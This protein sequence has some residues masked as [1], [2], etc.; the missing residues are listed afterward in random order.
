ME[1]PK[2]DGVQ[3]V[4]RALQ[5]LEILATSGERGVSELATEIGVHKSTTS[6]LLAALESHRLV[7]QSE[8]RG[9]Y[10]LG[11]GLVRLARAVT[12]QMDVSRA[13]RD[14]IGR[15]ADELGETVNVAV[16]RE[17]YAVNIEQALGPAAVSTYNWVGELTPL[18]ATS[19]GKVL[20]AHVAPSER[21]DLV[22]AAGL[23]K[24]TRRTVT[25]A[26]TLMA[27]LA[28]VVASGYA[29]TFGEL[30]AGL[31]AVAVPVVGPEGSVVAALSA[32]GPDYRLTP[33]RVSAVAGRLAEEA[34]EVS[35]RLGYLG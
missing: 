27:Q 9:R 26:K 10:Q 21:V 34:A 13:A 15:L 17:H 19:S 32:S 35:R 23:S 1:K 3:S 8:D 12:G 25:N 28:D 14:A 31:N 4:D 29:T 7:E 11:F 22:K 18:H 33:E 16:L 2:P 24:Y 6:R 30:E 5:L 20:L